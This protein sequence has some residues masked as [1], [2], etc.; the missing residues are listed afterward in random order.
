M[1]MKK[2]NFYKQVS[3][4]SKR[5]V[6]VK[7]NNNLDDLNEAKRKQKL[8]HTFKLTLVKNSTFS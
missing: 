3:H 1:C 8:L 2:V 5:L 6:S 7:R 4:F